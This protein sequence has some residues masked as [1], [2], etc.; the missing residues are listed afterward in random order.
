MPGG[1]NAVEPLCWISTYLEQQYENMALNV[2]VLLGMEGVT[3]LPLEEIIVIR[4]TA[5]IKVK[6]QPEAQCCDLLAPNV[7]TLEVRKY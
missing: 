7:M 2:Y 5:I 4:N 3:P 1:S 6:M